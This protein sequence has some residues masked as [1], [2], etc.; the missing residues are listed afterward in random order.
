VLFEALPKDLRQRL[1]ELPATIHR[2]E[3][4]AQR[5]RVRVNLQARIDDAGDRIGTHV[6]DSLDERRASALRDAQGARIEA[7]QRLRDAVSALEMFR[8]DLLRL[9]ARGSDVGSITTDLEAALALSRQV[10]QHADARAEVELLI[11]EPVSLPT[12]A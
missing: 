1:A 6:R 12:P 4:A 3:E 11:K 2:L 8:I 9:H 7:E 5:Q 10:Q